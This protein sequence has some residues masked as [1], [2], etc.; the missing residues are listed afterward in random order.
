MLL[1]HIGILG[2]PLTS[3]RF[4]TIFLPRTNAGLFGFYIAS[5]PAPHMSMPGEITTLIIYTNY[6]LSACCIS[7]YENST[8]FRYSNNIGKVWLFYCWL[9]LHMPMFNELYTSLSHVKL[10]NGSR[11]NS[12]VGDLVLFAII[13]FSIACIIN[14][15]VIY[16]SQQRAHVRKMNFVDN[17]LWR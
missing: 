17:T 7:L 10:K 15:V 12:I 8:P 4:M 2:I 11:L 1:Y 13:C 16:N 6:I 9:W 3:L 14:P 5:S